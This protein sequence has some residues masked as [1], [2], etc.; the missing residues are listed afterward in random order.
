MAKKGKKMH[1]Q[2]HSKIGHDGKFE[3]GERVIPDPLEPGQH[4]RAPMNVRES[5]IEH[6]L[7]RGRIDIAQAEA[8][9]RFRKLW[10]MAAIGHQRSVNMEGSGG[11]GHVGDS[12]SDALVKASGELDKVVRRLGK[13]RSR[14][15]VSILGEGRLIEQVAEQWSR[16]GGIV[17]GKRA[18]GYVSGTLIDAIDELVRLWQLKAMGRAK[19]KT[20]VYKRNGD[21]I[22]VNDSILASGPMSLSGPAS[23]ITIG[24]LGDPVVTQKRGV[25]S[26]PMT[27]H[28]VCSAESAPGSRR[29]SKQKSPKI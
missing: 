3:L 13:I 6:M 2:V 14:I 9:T 12:I 24:K 11:T 16:A 20:A 10:E 7:S 23:E 5:A 22:E 19:V 27:K 26:G 4:Y 17:S 21:A 25:D 18:E 15:L 28:T 29:R 1:A 8:G